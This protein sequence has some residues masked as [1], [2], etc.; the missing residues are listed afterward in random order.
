GMLLA[1]DSALVSQSSRRLAEVD[2]ALD[3][4]DESMKYAQKA[5]EI[6]TQ[7]GESSEIGL[8]RRVIARIFMARSEFD[9]AT[10]NSEQAV[11]TLASVGDPLEHGRALL[12]LAEI[13]TGQGSEEYERIQRVLEEAT[14]IFRKLG[15]DYWIAEA[16]FQAGVCACR[17]GEL[18]RGFKK[19]SRA[20]RT[21][22]SISEKGKVRAV[23]Q[24]LQSLAD[25]AVAL[26]VSD[27]NE[28]K[29]FGNL[30]SPSE[31]SD[32]K[33]GPIDEA[34]AVLLE[35]TGAD[36]A[37]IYSADFLD[38]PLI[39]STPLSGHQSKRFIDSFCQILGEEIAS[40]KPTLR[41]DCRRDPYIN[42]LFTDFPEPVAS[43]I[44][45]PFTMSDGTT[46]YLYLDKVSGNNLI[47]PFSQSAL[48]FAVGYSD[49]IA[50]K[51]AEMQ[52]M[53]LVEDNRRLKAQL[54]KEAA[55]PNIITRSS[56]MLE[57][58][59]QIRQ[60]VDSPIS[61]SIEGETGTGKDLLARAIHYNSVRRDKRFISVN[62][63]ALPETLLE[64]ELFGYRRGAFTGADRDK[65]GLFEE[66]DGGTFFLDE[67]ADMPV[68]IQAKILRI[69]EEKEIVRLGETVPRQVDVRIL[70]ATNK[71]LKN[72]IKSGTF[73]QDLYYRLSAL[74]FRLSPLR[75][76]KEDIPLLVDH[77]LVECDK[78]ISP[79]VM[80]S[81]VSYNWP[82][83]VRE[84]ENEV[85]KLILL[86]GDASEIAP[87]IVSAKISDD[88]EIESGSNASITGQPSQV[89]FT[90]DYS[91]YDFL[92]SHERRFIIEALKRQN[93]VKKHAAALLRIPES[94][95]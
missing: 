41:L 49:L 85:K 22:A 4:I 91:L 21:F 2:L 44:V 61:I 5:L 92:E 65:P 33:A 12:T 1:P 30:L 82:G 10:T 14:R 8:A 73:R 68:N 76:R 81:L 55:F 7:V 35:R 13:M 83:N 70:S 20:E 24:F 95:L 62:C 52:K 86:T 88:I 54:R 18:A 87:D 40:D 42:E 39:C 67:I 58:L 31:I 34:L 57:M 29:V 45:V 64:S 71:N 9:D 48:N 90:A 47:N 38:T 50:L 19:L 60:V 59:A 6:A 11:E 27:Q 46:S 43:I 78:T 63:A 84:L 56:A 36:R 75:E 74:T 15:L 51:A 37:L 80:K 94:T 69:M 17:R 32:L 72:E 25:Q 23:N 26:S 16:G 53:A 28:F 93:G 3:N 79:E 89:E 77:F 66:A